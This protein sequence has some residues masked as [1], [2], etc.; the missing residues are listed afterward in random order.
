MIKFTA[1]ADHVSAR[2]IAIEMNDK[3]I[4]I[5]CEIHPWNLSIISIRMV[6]DC[7][8]Y[9]ILGYCCKAHKSTLEKFIY[10][11]KIDNRLITSDC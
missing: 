2:Y 6:E 7:P 8:E 9:S 10:S 4:K 11:L 5:V 1:I 3:G